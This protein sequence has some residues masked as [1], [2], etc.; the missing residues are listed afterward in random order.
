MMYSRLDFSLRKKLQMKSVLL[1]MT[2]SHCS[3]PPKVGVEVDLA[4]KKILS[5]KI[6]DH[7]TAFYLWFVASPC[8]KHNLHMVLSYHYLNIKGFSGGMDNEFRMMSKL[9]M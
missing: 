1:F 2:S 7:S 3:L 5:P 4:S 9:I 8:P 6:V